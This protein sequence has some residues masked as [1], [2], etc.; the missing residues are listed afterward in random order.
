M[1]DGPPTPP[2]RYLLDLQNWR[3]VDYDHIE[4]RPIDYGI[5]SYT[6]GRLID[7][8]RT[9]ADDEKPE[10]VT[11]NI[12]YVPSLPLSR[13][14]A[15][16]K[17][18]GKRYVWW[19]WM[20]VPQAAGGH[21]LQG[22]D[23]EI[24]A[25]EIANQRNIYKRAK[26]S[27]VWLHGIEWAHYPLLA[28]FLEGKMRLQSQDHTN[29]RGVVSVTKFILEQIQAEEP[30]LTS[31]WTLQEGILLPNAPLVDSKG[32]KLQN[33][34]FPEGGAASVAS[35]TATVVPLASRIGDAFRDYSEKESFANEEYIVRFI[36][37]HDDNYEFMARFLAAL[38]R[39]GFVGYNSGAPLFLLAGKAS[40]KFSKPE[41]E[42][43]ALIGAMDINVPNPQYYNGL[44]MDRVMSMFFEPLLE[45]YQWRLFLIGRMMDD[46]WR[47]KSW[48]R[49]VVEGHALPLEIY[50]SVSWEERLPV[51]RLDPEI[52][53][54][55]HMTPHQEEKTIQ[56][57][58][59]EQ[60]V[61]C[62]RYKQSTY[63]DGFVRLTKIEEEFTKESLF[64]KVASLESLNKGDNKGLREGFRCI[65]IQRIT[66]NEGRFWGV[67]DVWKGGELAPGEQRSFYYRET[68]HFALW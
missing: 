57:I 36:Q 51:L 28:S 6:W 53:R 45:R 61:L 66:D 15:V 46:D 9:V 3:R 21:Q 13:A 5:V 26:A 60:H 27:I 47:T 56:L 44:Q 19:D 41:D 7:Q 49:R 33:T 22:E 11:W 50:F 25:H 42:C 17:T 29:F 59:N 14:K 2:P 64:L 52:P 23:A 58:D 35:I 67:A 55:L 12:P 43:W 38:I 24:A 4:E 65:E 48:P 1:A 34:I 8:T 39:S 16:M 10:H 68:A 40:R 31:G 37:A 30:W 62:R 63:Q 20:C 54:K 18:M 32:L